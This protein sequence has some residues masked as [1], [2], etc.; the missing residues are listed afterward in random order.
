M[1]EER[2]GPV[3]TTLASRGE[4]ILRFLGVVTAD[5]LDGACTIEVIVQ[6][7]GVLERH[8]RAFALSEMAEE[9][10]EL[11]EKAD[12]IDGQVPSDR[13]RIRA[14]ELRNGAPVERHATGFFRSEGGWRTNQFHHRGGH[15]R[16]RSGKDACRVANGSR[17]ALV[18]SEAR[19]TYEAGD[20]YV[21]QVEKI[22]FG[23]IFLEVVKP[24][25]R[26][27]NGHVYFRAI[28]PNGERWRKYKAQALPLPQNMRRTDWT[29]E[30]VQKS[31]K[32]V[33]DDS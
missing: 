18:D 21:W 28:G 23:P 29:D 8:I 20:R 9:L 1:S 33:T 32:K 7:L 14:N 5:A 26:A 25:G 30:D 12:R 19:E 11:A 3:T 4:T 16:W 2:Q 24:R 31:A 15:T 22:N 6:K 27:K 10:E 17:T 13:L